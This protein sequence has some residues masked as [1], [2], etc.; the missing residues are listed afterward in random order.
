[1]FMDLINCL[2]SHAEET[3]NEFFIK[4]KYIWMIK[5][6]NIWIKDSEAVLLLTI[7]KMWCAASA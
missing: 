2:L 4:G 5:T 7:K 6:L 3:R 1:M